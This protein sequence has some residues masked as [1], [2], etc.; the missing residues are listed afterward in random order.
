MSILCWNYRGLGNPQTIQELRTSIR[1]KS[2]QL[3]FLS[4][5]KCKTP[6]IEKIKRYLN[7]HGFSVDAQGRSGGLALL[8]RKDVSVSLR[9]FSDNFIDVDT[10]L[11][12]QAFRFTG[13]YREPNVSLRRQAW[14]Q[15]QNLYTPLT[16]HGSWEAILMR[17]SDPNVYRNRRKGIF[18]FEALWVRA[19]ECEDI[20]KKHWRTDLDSLPNK[21]ENCSVG[22]LNWGRQHMRDLNKHVDELK[23]QI[24][25]LQS[26]LITEDTK[27]ILETLRQRL[28][29]L[30]DQLDLKWKQRA[31]HH[32]YKEGDRNTKFF[33]NSAS[34]RRES[35]HIDGLKD[36]SGSLQTSPEGIECIILDYF[37]SLFTSASPS[38]EDITQAISRIRPRPDSW[39]WLPNKNNK[40]S[41]KSAYHVIT[42]SPEFLPHSPH[43]DT[44]D[45]QIQV[46]K[47]LWTLKIPGRI[48]HFSWRLLTDTLPTTH[49]FLRRHIPS[50]THFPLC[51]AEDSPHSHLFFLCPFA[52]Q[53][54][55][56]SGLA[57]LILLFQQ[58]HSHLW[59]REFIMSNP[60]HISAYFL[61]L[62]SLIWYARN[63]KLFDNKNQAPYS[64]VAQAS[65]TLL[66]FQTATLHPKRPSPALQEIDLLKQAPPSTHIFFDGAISLA[67]NC[68]GA[69][70]FIMH[71]D[72]SFFK[73]V[74]KCFPGISD[75]ALAEAL[76]LREA[77]LLAQSLQ[78]TDFSFLGDAAIIISAER[79]GSSTS[80][81]IDMILQDIWT[82][83]NSNACLG[84]FWIPRTKNFVAHEFAFYAKNSSC[85]LNSWDDPP[86]FLLQLALDLFQ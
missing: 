31:K 20:I 29:I 6:V 13:F 86:H 82:L 79:N 85:L 53:V 22:L 50:S 67:R 76:A 75:A 25:K 60:S 42:N 38:E 83:I 5:T 36:A 55:A 51:E 57:D 68:A 10:E 14:E 58:P 28:E 17:R 59:A 52:H 56:L 63:Q 62:C 71:S 11:M 8:W 9:K 77:A 19:D 2:P 1:N 40:F 32:W 37:G 15:L 16:Y 61:T 24:T 81:D 23:D 64:L 49:N 35:N 30:L 65:H 70:I 84:F 34:I 39:S 74:S 43:G 12:G 78:L 66:T 21:I 46:W 45:S 33:H 27:R 47:K 7:L 41:V 44:S 73:G 72:G 4:E 69:G 54:W 3:V 18:R 80:S 26:G 48:A